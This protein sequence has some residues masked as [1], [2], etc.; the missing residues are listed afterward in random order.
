MQYARE[1]KYAHRISLEN[2]KRRRNLGDISAD[3]K[4]ILKLIIQK[5]MEVCA[6]FLWCIIET[7][8]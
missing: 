7:I 6:A 5:V 8:L 4:I 2:L 1:R 3:V